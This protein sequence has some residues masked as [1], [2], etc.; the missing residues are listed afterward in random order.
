MQK[1][2]QKAPGR[3]FLYGSYAVFVFVTFLSSAIVHDPKPR[4]G[5]EA[6]VSDLVGLTRIIFILIPCLLGGSAAFLCYLFYE[7]R[8]NQLKWF[9]KKNFDQGL[10]HLGFMTITVIIFVIGN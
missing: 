2:S 1:K 6:G 3:W 5:N 10:I 7:N 9:S 4:T 8:W